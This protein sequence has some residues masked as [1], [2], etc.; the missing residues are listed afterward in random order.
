M[1]KAR[2]NQEQDRRTGVDLGQKKK[3]KST[4]KNID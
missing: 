3:K 4:V 2:V 1:N